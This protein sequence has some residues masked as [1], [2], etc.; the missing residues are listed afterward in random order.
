MLL[1]SQFVSVLSLIREALEDRD[2][3]YAYLDGQTTNRLEVC[4]RFNHDPS[5]PLFLISLRAGGTGLNLTG[6]DTVVHYDPWWNP[7]VEAQ[8]TDRAHR[9]GQTRSVTSLKLITAGSVE[10]T[11][12]ALQEKKAGILRDLL[13]DSAVSTARVGI[14]EIMAL[15]E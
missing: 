9:I 11:V 10:E 6:A 12:L 1:F 2:L 7:A 3:P 8:A 13:D 4:D 15:L 14:G 5:I